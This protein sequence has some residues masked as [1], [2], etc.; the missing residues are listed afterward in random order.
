MKHTT[1]K[2]FN[3][4]EAGLQPDA[5]RDEAQ[6]SAVGGQLYAYVRDVDLP[7]GYVE[8]YRP[9]L[10]FREPTLCDASGHMGGFA[11][12]DRYLLLSA[13]ARHLDALFGGMSGSPGSGLCVFQPD[14]LWKVLAIHRG[15][16]HTQITLLEVPPE[17]ILAFD[18]QTLTEF[19]QEM[20]SR[21]G[22]VF[23][24]TARLEPLAACSTPEWL[25]R[26][27]HPLGIKDDGEFM[28]CWFNGMHRGDDATEPPPPDQTE[29][30]PESAA[31]TLLQP[32]TPRA[33]LFTRLVGLTVL[34]IGLGIAFELITGPR[35]P[36]KVVL[37]LVMIGMGG[38]VAWKP[39]T[40]S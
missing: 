19:E 16:D 18:C 31:N 13:N 32:L 39:D 2:Q 15:E 10:I 27:Q 26:L 5:S 6:M 28:E 20:A 12:H 25:E 23:E 24:S 33:R 9:G 30:P 29:T 7:P 21:A 14:S 38:L 34:L 22:I 3:T 36:Q 1:E 37:S 40:F 11:A 35:P 4:H 8:R 17:G